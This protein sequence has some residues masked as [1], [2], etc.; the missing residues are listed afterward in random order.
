[1]HNNIFSIKERHAFISEFSNETDLRLKITLYWQ[2]Q[3]E[4]IKALSVCVY[5]NMFI[6]LDYV[7]LY[8]YNLFI[9]NN[10]I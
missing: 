5:L 10:E 8:E 2:I 3:F 6:D 7:N 9:Y 4:K 1:M